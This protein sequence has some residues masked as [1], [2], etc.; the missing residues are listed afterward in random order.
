MVEEGY[1]F[2]KEKQYGDPWRRRVRR[3]ALFGGDELFVP[4]TFVGTSADR[5]IR[6]GGG[7]TITSLARS[8]NSVAFLVV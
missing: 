1:G 5:K 3:E 2:L 7:C 6:A 4:R 8:L